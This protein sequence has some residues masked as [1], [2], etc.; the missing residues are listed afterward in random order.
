MEVRGQRHVPA[1]L[2]P[3]GPIHSEAGWAPETFWTLER[4]KSICFTGN[5]TVVPQSSSL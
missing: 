5:R 3:R 2:P 1:V 4:R